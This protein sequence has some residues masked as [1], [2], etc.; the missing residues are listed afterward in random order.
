MTIDKATQREPSLHYDAVDNVNSRPDGTN[1]YLQ[2]ELQEVKRD[3]VT[4][5]Q[6]DRGNASTYALRKLRKDSPEIHAEVVDPC[7]FDL[8]HH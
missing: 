3:N 6:P 4:V 1:Q 8:I 5:D 2:P 7:P